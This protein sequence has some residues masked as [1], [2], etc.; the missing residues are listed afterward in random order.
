MFTTQRPRF[1]FSITQR[2]RLSLSTQVVLGLV[3]GLVVGVCAGNKAAWLQGIG[4]AFILLLQMTVLPYIRARPRVNELYGI[5]LVALALQWSWLPRYAEMSSGR[6]TFNISQ[7]EA[8]FNTG[9]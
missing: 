3:L 8:A 5:L 2:P 1:R 4:K 9:S 7:S 6:G